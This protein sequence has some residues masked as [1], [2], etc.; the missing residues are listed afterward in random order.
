[1]A[2]I[3]TDNGRKVNTEWFDEDERKKYEQ[4]EKAQKKADELNGKQDKL[5][6]LDNDP[7]LEKVV[8][9]AFHKAN[10]MNEP[11][12]YKALYSYKAIREL[13]D[14]QIEILY[15]HLASRLFGANY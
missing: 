6:F 8:E 12:I 3:T 2:W 11:D 4:I 10:L 9:K 14:D 5:S 13:D 7:K 1:M 15:E